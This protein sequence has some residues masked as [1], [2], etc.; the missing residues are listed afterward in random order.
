MLNVEKERVIKQEQQIN[1]HLQ[2]RVQFAV[3]IA[4]ILVVEMRASVIYKK[5]Y[6]H[7]SYYSR[8]KL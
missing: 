5:N 6:F 1:S 8:V 2:A 7:F 3:A 4:I